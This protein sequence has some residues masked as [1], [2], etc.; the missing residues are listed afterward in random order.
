MPRTFSGA[1]LDFRISPGVPVLLAS[2][3]PSE[4]NTSPGKS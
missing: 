4:Q 1:A 2:Y 3:Y